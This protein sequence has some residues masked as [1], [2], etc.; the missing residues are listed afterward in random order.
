ML[1]LGVV[2]AIIT[3]QHLEKPINYDI[4]LNIL[5]NGEAYTVND[6][7]NEPYQVIRPPTK[8][9]NAAA[10]VIIKLL[11]QLQFNQELLVK[12]QAEHDE[13]TNQLIKFQQV[14]QNVATEA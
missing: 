6:G 14:Q 4:L 1:H 13:T 10:D 12:L 7:I 3:T 5:K 9:S 8:H 11:H 2:W